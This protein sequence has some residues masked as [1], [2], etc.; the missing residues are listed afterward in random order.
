MARRLPRLSVGPVHCCS[1]CYAAG[2]AEVLEAARGSM[3][4]RS[5]RPPPGA[6]R[7][8][9]R[10]YGARHIQRAAARPA[11]TA[12]RAASRRAS[13]GR[14]SAHGRIFDAAAEAPAAA[15]NRSSDT[16]RKCILCLSFPRLAMAQTA[17]VSSLDMTQCVEGLMQLV[18]TLTP[19]VARRHAHQ[20]VVL[21][22][23]NT[24]H[25]TLRTCV[26]TCQINIGYLGPNVFL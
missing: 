1:S 20:R 9:S 5:P 18:Q 21:G 24:I 23:N 26:H 7:E 16:K 14:A 15:F 4:P 13:G 12:W 2:A 19:H 25:A 6:I 11:A 22:V 17:R 8:S 10:I 3:P